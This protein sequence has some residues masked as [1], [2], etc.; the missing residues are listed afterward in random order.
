MDGNHNKNGGIRNYLGTKSTILS[1]LL[2]FFL[3]FVLYFFIPEV[4]AQNF[5]SI[6]E[7]SIPI[8][9]G[10]VKTLLLAYYLSVHFALF[11]Q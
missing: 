11:L 6:A 10:N 2:F 1:Y 9:T 7:R 5:N 4:V 8:G 3:I